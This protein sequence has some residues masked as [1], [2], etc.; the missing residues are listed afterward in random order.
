MPLLNVALHWPDGEI[1][2]RRKLFSGSSRGPA[3]PENSRRYNKDFL[4]DGFLRIFQKTAEIRR[5]LNGRSR[6]AGNPRVFEIARSGRRRD[7]KARR[8]P[9]GRTAIKF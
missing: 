4:T 6:I 7:E 5:F 2:D 8:N 1:F 3:Q 9:A